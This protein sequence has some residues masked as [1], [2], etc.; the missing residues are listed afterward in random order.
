VL[1]VKFNKSFIHIKCCLF[2]V[3]GEREIR[4]PDTLRHAGFRNRSFQPLTHL[5]LLATSQSSYPS[6]F[7]PFNARIQKLTG[8]WNALLASHWPH[9]SK[10]DGLIV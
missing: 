2:F 7:T 10:T 3:C 9:V 5:S 4:T 8:H 1:V 6:I